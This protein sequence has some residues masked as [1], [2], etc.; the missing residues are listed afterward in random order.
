MRQG[1]LSPAQTLVRPDLFYR[2]AAEAAW[3]AATFIAV[4]KPRTAKYS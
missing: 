3:G 1:R 2:A 4:L